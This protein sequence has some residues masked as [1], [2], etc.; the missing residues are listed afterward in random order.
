MRCACVSKCGMY[1]SVNIS[2]RAVCKQTH[3]HK[4]GTYQRDDND[5]LNFILNKS[6]K[7]KVVLLCSKS[8]SLYLKLCFSRLLFLI[9]E[10]KMWLNIN[11]ITVHNNTYF[12]FLNSKKLLKIKKLHNKL[13]IYVIYIHTQ[14]HCSDV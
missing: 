7:I 3:N 10:I 5:S 2:V 11:H 1:A 6:P 12:I 8:Q 13:V 14:S 4:T 9:R